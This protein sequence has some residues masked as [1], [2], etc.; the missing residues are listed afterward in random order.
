ML[1][2]ICLKSLEL[3]QSQLYPSIVHDFENASLSVRDDSL[4]DENA[5]DRSS[6]RLREIAAKCMVEAIAQSRI[7]IADSTQTRRDGR[8]FEYNTGDLVDFHRKPDV[9]HAKRSTR[10]AWTSSDL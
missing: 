9:I 4:G 1:K 2:T 8:E 6:V 7:A 5:A 10:L 3:I